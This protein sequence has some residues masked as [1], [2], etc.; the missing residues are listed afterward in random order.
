MTPTKARELLDRR[1]ASHAAVIAAWREWVDAVEADDKLRLDAYAYT[2]NCAE[3][4][5]D[6]TS[7]REDEINYWR[8]ARRARNATDVIDQRQSTDKWCEAD[9]RAALADL[10]VG[11]EK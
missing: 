3:S 8:S 1:R 9:L 5:Q 11:L 4:G 7:T 6:V 2:I 10:W